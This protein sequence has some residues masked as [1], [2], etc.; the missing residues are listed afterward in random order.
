MM[1]TRIVVM[2]MARHALEKEEKGDKI[3]VHQCM[4]VERTIRRRKTR[5]RG[6]RVSPC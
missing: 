5:I 6:R 1:Y 4:V 3:I 2:V